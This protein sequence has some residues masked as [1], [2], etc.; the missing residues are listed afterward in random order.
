MGLEQH[1]ELQNKTMIAFDLALGSGALLAP[2]ATLKVLGHAEP[3]D[4]AR[5][6]FRRCGPIW[7]T[8][9]AAHLVA[10]KRGTAGGLV[11]AG[12][13][14][15]H[16]ALHRHHLVALPGDPRQPGAGGVDLRRVRERRDGRGL[17]LA[18]QAPMILLTGGTGTVGSA[19]LRRLTAAG[20]PVRCLVRD[21]KRL[22]PERVR[23]AWPSATSPTRPRSATPCAAS[24]RSSTSGPRSAISRAARSRSSTRWPPCASSGPPSAPARGGSS[25]S[26]RWGPPSSRPPG[27]SG[28]R[29]SRAGRSRTP[30]SR[31]R[32]S[33]RRSSTPRAIPG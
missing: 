19:L 4:D 7:L 12:V 17:R 32:C 15:R 20:T 10:A 29:R 22:G 13:A 3:S 31:R 9:A 8:F 24:T 14:A 16:R 11:G 28:P 2:D 18:R 21:P 25:S 23:V 1:L 27:S 33:R 26:R 30:T 5:E 6:I